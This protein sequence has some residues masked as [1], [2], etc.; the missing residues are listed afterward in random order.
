MTRSRSFDEN[1]VLDAAA[2]VF[3]KRGYLSASIK[4]LEAETGLTS[5]SIYNAYRDKAGLFAAALDRYVQGFV[6]VRVATYAG[7]H[8]TIDDLEK[9][10]FSVIEGPLADG[11]G[12]L[13]VNSLVEFGSGESIAQR[14]MKASLDLVQDGIES[15]L[16]RELGDEVARIEAARLLLLYYGA[17]VLSRGNVLPAETAAMLRDEFEHLRRLKKASPRIRTP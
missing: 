5:G 2:N 1:A 8:A 9:L 7:E 3:R 10:V 4:E 14:G 13:A 17:L 12:C 6:A 16:R 15:V 11:Y